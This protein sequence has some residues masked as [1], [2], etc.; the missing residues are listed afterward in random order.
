MR[1]TTIVKTF[2][3]AMASALVVGITATAQ[4]ADKGCSN[5]T[6]KGTY[7]YTNTGFIT[8]PPVEAG[9]FAGVGT[10]VFDGNGGTTATAW[11][12]QNGN[13]LQVAI[14]GTYTVNRDCT[15]TLTLQISPVSITGHAFFVISDDGAKLRAIN[16]DPGSVITTTGT[17]QFQ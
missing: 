16:T 9:P 5:A 3:M 14:T 7:A 10:Q 4:A 6:L 1:Q 13:V 17:R 8:A 12:S 15:G 11:V 2:A